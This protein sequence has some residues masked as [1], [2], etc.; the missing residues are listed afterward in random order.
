[1]LSK[2]INKIE[3][4]GIRK[5][6]ELA[7][8][9]KGEYVNFSIGQPHFE[10][11]NLLKEAAQRAIAEN[12]NSYTPT[13]GL[14]DLRQEIAQN[15]KQTRGVEANSD[16]VIITAGTSGAIFLLF[17]AIFD[18][19]DEVILPDPYFVLYKQVL[20]FLEVKTVFLDTYPD[21]HID[22]DKLESLVT[23]KTKAIIINSPNNPTGAV[24]G[25]QEIEGVVEVAEKNDLI[26][27]SDEIYEAFDYDNQFFSPASIYD[28]TFVLSGFSKSHS[29][30]GWRVGFAHGSSEVIEAMN[31]LQQYTF[32][33][34][35][36]FAQ[37][38]LIGNTKEFSKQE[39]DNY[40]QKRDLVY[41]ELKKDYNFIRPEGAFYAFVEIPEKESEFIKKCLDNKLLVVPGSVFSRK[42]SHFRISFAVDDQQLKKGLEILATKLNIV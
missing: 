4:S 16:N 22:S 31:K 20:D 38:A 30:T 28:K 14:P 12:F 29:I 23:D 41:R 15:L 21:F 39:I 3:T 1:M 5:I 13:K 11:P 8:K 2:R 6:F 26:I 10:T 37:K 42:S 18:A 40:K 34:A 32:V 19:G 9:N 17:S 35:P 36:S 25:K 7:A 27:I 24:Y 33:C